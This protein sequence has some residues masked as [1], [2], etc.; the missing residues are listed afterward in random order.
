M[1]TRSAPAA[2]ASYAARSTTLRAT[3]RPETPRGVDVLDLRDAVEEVELAEPRH[4]PV[5]PLREE[6]RSHRPLD[7]PAEIGERLDEG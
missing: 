3:P 5:D 2:R 7:H 1:R 6:S 4:P